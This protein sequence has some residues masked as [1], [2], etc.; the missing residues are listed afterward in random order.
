MSPEEE[1]VTASELFEEAKT[2][3][4]TRSYRSNRRRLNR[5]KQRLELLQKEFLE[6]IS[7]VDKNFFQRLNDSFLKIEDKKDGN[8][9]TFFNEHKTWATV[10][11]FIY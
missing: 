9:F 1:P 8:K 10:I 11:F 2:S 7:K 5:R 6:E 4:D 3:A